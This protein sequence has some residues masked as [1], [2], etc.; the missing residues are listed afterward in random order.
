VQRP[1]NGYADLEANGGFQ[2]PRDVQTSW[3]RAIDALH[4]LLENWPTTP[5]LKGSVRP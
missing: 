4:V 3:R 2:H 5:V 1:E